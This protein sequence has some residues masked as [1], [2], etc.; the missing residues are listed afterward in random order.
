MVMPKPKTNIIM[1]THNTTHIFDCIARAAAD[2]DDDYHHVL[3]QVC[4]C[5]LRLSAVFTG[6]N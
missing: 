5:V 6:L 3:L 2:N 1:F 4:F